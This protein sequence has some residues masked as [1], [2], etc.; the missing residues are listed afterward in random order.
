MGKVIACFLDPIG[1]IGG[2]L[3]QWVASIEWYWWALLGAV[4][5]GIVWKL[6]GWPGL[7]A[8]A[9]GAGFL[10]GRRQPTHEDDIWPDPDKPVRRS[11]QKPPKRKTVRTVQWWLGKR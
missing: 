1:C 2:A 4:F 3:W 8:L 10:L 7:L 5:V 6:A 9:A 11:S